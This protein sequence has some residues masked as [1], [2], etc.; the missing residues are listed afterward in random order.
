MELSL[1]QQIA[2]HRARLAQ[3]R[4]QRAF[5]NLGKTN[6]VRLWTFRRNSNPLLQRSGS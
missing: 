4:M 1:V 5:R 6:V 2:A 3:L